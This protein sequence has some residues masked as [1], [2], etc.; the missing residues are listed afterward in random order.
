LP[1]VQKVR[2]A[3]ARLSCSNNLKQIGLATHNYH[4]TMGKFPT[5][6]HL[7]VDVGGRPAG[8]TTLWAEV[9]PY[10]EQD[11]KWDYIDNSNNVTGERDATQAHVIK[12]LL[13]PS[14]SLPEPVSQFTAPGTPPWSWG[15]YGM[16][17][18]GG[19]AGRRSVLSSQMTRDGIFYIDSPVRLEDVK[20]GTS[21]TFLF[22]ERFHRDSVHD[23]LQP[24]VWPEGSPLGR[25]GKW[26]YVAD[27]RANANVTLSTPV[28]IN[29]R[30]LPDGNATMLQDRNCA[31][32]S[33]H[34]GGAN[35]AFADGSVRFLGDGTALSVLQA[36]STRARGEVI[37]AG[38]F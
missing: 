27:P 14:D 10:L 18:Y 8:G 36:L 11:L 31:F 26:G 9:L 30:V 38:D 34:L 28:P 13:C 6:A 37:S 12:V 1:A 33:G 4:D 5:G 23:F 25:V 29:F 7:P 3:A 20:D 22:G 17:S 19:N 2:E 32:G 15:F 21:S 35:F 16:S 24:K